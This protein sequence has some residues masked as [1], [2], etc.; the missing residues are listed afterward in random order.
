MQA[1]IFEAEILS[2]FQNDPYEKI[3]TP[4][5]NGRSIQ[6]ADLRATAKR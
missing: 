1:A 5:C 3:A 6:F 4:S 2:S